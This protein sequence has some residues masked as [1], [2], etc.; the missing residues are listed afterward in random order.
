MSNVKQFPDKG[1]IPN[2]EKLGLI[3]ATILAVM[4][5]LSYTESFGVLEVVKIVLSDACREEMDEVA[6]QLDK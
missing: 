3:T 1:V 2:D 6:K 5:D 4:E